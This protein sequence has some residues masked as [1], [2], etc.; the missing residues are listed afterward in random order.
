MLSWFENF[1]K[2]DTPPEHIWEDPE[3]LEEWWDRVKERREIRASGGGRQG[4][5]S[6]DDSGSAD[7]FEGNEL[8]RVLKE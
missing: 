7:E 1:P 4:P 2:E 5:I 8:A 6:D 3:G